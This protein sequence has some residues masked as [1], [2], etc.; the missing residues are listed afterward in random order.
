MSSIQCGRGSDVIASTVLSNAYKV[1]ISWLC[2]HVKFRRWFQRHIRSIHHISYTLQLQLTFSI[3]DSLFFRLMMSN[4]SSDL[5]LTHL[6]TYKYTFM[7]IIEFYRMRGTTS[8]Y[9]YHTHT[10]TCRISSIVELW[11]FLGKSVFDND[12]L[13]IWLHVVYISLA[14]DVLSFLIWTETAWRHN[15]L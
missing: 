4:I 1:T 15:S 13:R 11:W 3:S 12:D 2:T 8:L 10:R 7:Q 14:S 6:V 5:T 9:F